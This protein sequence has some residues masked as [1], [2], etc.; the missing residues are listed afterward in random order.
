MADIESVS[1]NGYHGGFISELPTEQLKKCSENE[2]D[3]EFKLVSEIP[4]NYL[5]IMFLGN[6]FRCNLPH[7]FNY[8][9]RS[10]RT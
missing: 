9:K 8:N 2:L 1:V 7:C 4:E 10:H 6:N 5:R 3:M